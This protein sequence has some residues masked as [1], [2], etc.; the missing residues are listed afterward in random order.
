[1]LSRDLAGPGRNCNLPV[2]HGAC[3]PGILAA[4]DLPDQTAALKA[5]LDAVSGAVTQ[6]MTA[7]RGSVP[8][9]L[10]YKICGKMFAILSLRNEQF[11]I[12]KCDPF[13]ADMLRQTYRGIGHRSHLDPRYWIS[14][15]LDA[16]VPADEISALVLH[17]RDQVAVTL[18]RKQRAELA[19]LRANQ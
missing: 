16:D 1:M 15:D 13:R 11:V 19:L 5:M 8:L 2:L 3:V 12:L 7:S 6:P 18:T 9:V 14:V 17:S 10:I 4:M